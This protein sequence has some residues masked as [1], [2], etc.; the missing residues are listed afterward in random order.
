MADRRLLAQFRIPD[1][2]DSSPSPSQPHRPQSGLQWLA[3]RQ[4]T[5]TDRRWPGLALPE[6]PGRLAHGWPRLAEKTDW[7]FSVLCLM[8]KKTTAV[9]R[10]WLIMEGRVEEG[11]S[12]TP[13]R[14][15]CCTHML[16]FAFALCCLSHLWKEGGTWASCH[17]SVLMRVKKAPCWRRKPGKKRQGG[18][19]ACCCRQTAFA[20][21]TTTLPA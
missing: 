16:P 5:G 10:T 20:V 8:W 17:A 11:G 7:A 6:K 15:L 1:S 2:Q 18:R 9:W 21:G 13:P 14:A 3:D 4:A 19:H 12:P